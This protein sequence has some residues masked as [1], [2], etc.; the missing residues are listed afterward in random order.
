MDHIFADIL[1]PMPGLYVV[2]TERNAGAH[3]LATLL[4]RALHARGL[5]VGVMKPVETGCPLEASSG[6]AVSYGGQE[7]T[8]DDET[9]GALERL[10]KLA[11]P[12]PST[13]SAGVPREH[14]ACPR[15]SSLVSAS[16][17]EAD[18]D[19]VNPF[20]FAPELEPGVAAQ[21]AGVTLEMATIEQSFSALS[22]S[23]DL[24]VVEGC[25]GVL[26]PLDMHLTQRDLIKALGLS[27]VL[28]APSRVGTISQ[29]LMTVDALDAEKVPVAGLVLNR[30]AADA[31]QPEEA[32]NPLFIETLRGVE[33]RGVLPH[34]EDEQLEDVDYLAGR[35]E[36]HVDLEGLLDGVI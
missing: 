6:A 4:A 34:F 28:V 19:L 7:L 11:G 24:M 29:C 23:S 32:A 21:L 20:R 9:L 5:D 2:G 1:T 10:S 36:V 13:H 16:G 30:T 35:L 3:L 17:R 31:I 18:L 22:R 15:A 27:V 25:H 12:P 26:S 8:L 33:V 14:L